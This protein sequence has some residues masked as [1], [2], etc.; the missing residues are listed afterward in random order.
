MNNPIIFMVIGALLILFFC[1]LTYRSTATWR[2]WHVLFAFLVFA[3][4]LALC[5]ITSATLRTHNAWRMV[6]GD[7]ADQ[8]EKLQKEN[9]QLVSGDPMQPVPTTPCLR[10]IHAQVRRML[11]DRGRVWRGCTPSQVAPDG[12]VT[13]STVAAVPP[14]PPPS[15]EAG[16]AAPPAG[17]RPAPAPNGIAQSTIL[18]VF[19]ERDPLPDQAE[20]A[21]PAGGSKLPAGTKLP[22]FYLGEFTA[23]AVTDTSVTLQPTAPLGPA[24]TQWMRQPGMT[25]CLY[26]RIPADGHQFFAVD[27]NRQPAWNRNADE[28]PIFGTIDMQ[29]LQRLIPPPQRQQ[30]PSDE[31][32]QRVQDVYTRLMD[33]YRR[34]G[35]RAGEGDPP[36]N[37]WL[38]VEFTQAHTEEVD[39]AGDPLQVLKVPQ[40]FFDRGRAGIAVLRRGGKIELKKGDIAVLPAEEANRLI[41]QVRVCKLIE[42][43][44]VRTLNDYQAGFQTLRQRLAQLQKSYR[45]TQRDSEEIT[46]ANDLVLEQVR[47]RDEEKTKLGQDLEK[48]QYE[49]DQITQYAATMAK[50]FEA[51]REEL[52]RLYRT[53]AQ[54]AV[55][56]ARLDQEMTEAINRRAPAPGSG[57]D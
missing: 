6:A 26:E 39:M 25:W 18:H 21:A 27:P 20:K 13:V 46:R 38:K 34:D 49:R 29:T 53:N 36:G 32:F 8:I 37:V 51:L 11:I 35:R 31:A 48:V 40:G 56:L 28:E 43:V 42:P 23:A 17:G 33:S 50:R 5:V 2:V 7:Q 4:S 30:F 9:E 3:A 14:A 15:P 45:Q 55:E 41:N 54:L 24:E 19:I 47:S 10:N 22:G 52:G 1:Y 44:Y 16:A 12:S 57:S